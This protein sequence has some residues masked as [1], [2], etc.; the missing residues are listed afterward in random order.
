V[1][2]LREGI[3]SDGFNWLQWDAIMRT[4]LAIQKFLRN[5]LAR[6]LKDNTLQWYEGRLRPF[7]ETYPELPGEAEAIEEFLIQGNGCPETKHADFRALRALYRLMEARYGVSNPIKTVR[8][9]RCPRKVMPTLEFEEMA[10]LLAVASNFRDKTLLTLFIDTG[11]RASEVAGL[12]RENIKKSSIIV[13]G[14]EGEREIPVSQETRDMLVELAGGNEYVFLGRKGR[15]TRHGIYRIVRGC[16]R[17]AGIGGP[18]LGPHRLRHAFGKGWLVNGGDLPSL[19]LVMGHVR[20]TTTQKYVALTLK[21]T[22]VK[23][24]HFTP[25]RAVT[26]RG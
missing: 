4:E 17:K 1:L 16:M 20:L 18:K 26:V 12:R 14:K 8:A 11:A 22:T 13:S 5:R 15:L 19:Q 3:S 9:P 24:E 7:A 10:R 6:K 23:H 21:D 25:L 2:K